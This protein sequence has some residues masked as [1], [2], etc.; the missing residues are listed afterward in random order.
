MKK[1]IILIIFVSLCFL[2]SAVSC[3]GIKK[4]EKKTAPEMPK[5]EE[6]SK[7]TVPEGT[8]DSADPK[9]PPAAA[10]KA[11]EKKPSVKTDTVAEAP[12][13][14]KK[15]VPEEKKPVIAKKTENQG[16]AVPAEKGKPAA[17]PGTA[18]P[19]AA[20]KA[21]ATPAVKAE[22]PA[23]SAP[24]AKTEAPATAK[25]PE[26]SVKP[27]TPATPARQRETVKT[28]DAAQSKQAAKPAGKPAPDKNQA[29]TAA[30]S[31]NE[32]GRTPGETRGGIAKAETK[33]VKPQPDKTAAS[34]DPA[35]KKALPANG[36]AAKPVSPQKPAS[37]K[38][39]SSKQ[40]VS[41]Q[42]T[43]SSPKPAAAQ[44]PASSPK[45][46]DSKPAAAKKPVPAAEKKLP[47]KQIAAAK[48]ET[49]KNEQPKQPARTERPASGR[50]R[51]RETRPAPVTKAAPVQ[52]RK[53]PDNA[54]KTTAAKPEPQKTNGNTAEGLTAKTPPAPDKDFIENLMKDAPPLPPE[55][56]DHG[57][58]SEFPSTEPGDSKE[59]NI[60]RSVKLFSG[61][62]LQLDYPGEG[63]V[64]LGESTAQKGIK[65][66][67]R[68]LQDGKTV[69]T[70]GAE[71]KGSYIL[72]FSRFD[73]F[74]DDFIAD[75]VSV[76]VENSFQRLNNIVKAPAFKAEKPEQADMAIAETAARMQN[77]APV[78]AV[79]AV[80]ANVSGANTENGMASSN[81]VSS[82]S[83]NTD[84]KN[85]VPA[86]STKT[87]SEPAVVYDSPDV[88]MAMETKTGE[89]KTAESSADE[90][91]ESIKKFI[92]AG[93]A[94]AALKDLNEFFKNHSV[95]ADEAWFLR[96]QAYELNGKE[97]NIKLALNAYQ[98]V[99]DAYPESA[100]WEEA[101]A[102]V[103]YIR[104]FYVNID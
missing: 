51:P 34:A 83:K 45:P 86:E 95:K 67:Q 96:G 3:T 42:K 46:A 21:G 30:T 59:P 88:L 37:S 80:A 102:R 104:K 47:A 13:T 48:P 73:V 15:T 11:E 52:P 40:P 14:E 84:V 70:F 17:R 9:R 54:P 93:N 41:P 1:N 5:I 10:G 103:R 44:K 101:D 35:A 26:T 57:F 100:R 31:K 58:F 29:K 72:N 49:K 32:S 97:K 74:S 85:E 89:T 90:S 4:A 87:L 22:K 25:A 55:N 33:P 24:A 75:S 18:R 61:Q 79:P 63:W 68:K 64:Y 20:G 65:Y 16:A 66:Q 56:E 91:L 43:T 77:A 7:Q 76:E 78:P 6:P 23:K 53:T 94:A 38:P 27:K 69:F 39:A 19:P 92:A 62:R 82:D 28:T 12:Q 36:A 60:S 8:E 71:N 50:E 2:F 81:P 99:V 98:T